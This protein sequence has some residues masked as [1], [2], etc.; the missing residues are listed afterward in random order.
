VKRKIS[1]WAVT[2]LMLILLVPSAAWA[3]ETYTLTLTYEDDF[4]PAYS[5][6]FAAGEVVTLDPHIGVVRRAQK[7]HIGLDRW[8][9]QNRPAGAAPVQLEFAPHPESINLKVCSLTM[10]ARDVELKAFFEERHVIV[11]KLSE[12]QKKGVQYH[13]LP[14]AKAPAY[15]LNGSDP[16]RPGYVFTG[17]N[18]APG[19]KLTGSMTCIAQW[20]KWA[21]IEAKAAGQGVEIRIPVDV[22]AFNPGNLKD[23]KGNILVYGEDFTYREGSTII[24][25]TPA[26]LSRQAGEETISLTASFVTIAEDYTQTTHEVNVSVEMPKPAADVPQTGDSSSLLV[27]CCALGAALMLLRRREAAG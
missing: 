21:P 11:Y 19:E 23:A 10:P 1:F 14:G 22:D 8:V 12:D 4:M 20:E 26:Y 2:L 18:P 27:W 6:E 3:Q 24:E 7:N 9:E 17:W 15:S 25:L 16:V 5:R 13:C